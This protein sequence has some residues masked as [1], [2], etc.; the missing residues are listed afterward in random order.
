MYQMLLLALYEVT[1]APIW[2]LDELANGLDGTN[3]QLLIGELAQAK[4]AGR[5][6]I[7]VTHQQNEINE[8]ADATYTIAQKRLFE[9]TKS[10]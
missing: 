9:V 10:D 8:L 6:I 7:L 4:R 5:T 1:A 3:L 2:L